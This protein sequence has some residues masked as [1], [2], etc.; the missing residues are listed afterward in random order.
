MTGSAPSIGGP[1]LIFSALRCWRRTALSRCFCWRANSFWRFWYVWFP[2]KV[3]VAHLGQPF[4]S[5]PGLGRG[6]S[7]RIPS[8]GRARGARQIRA[9]KFAKLT[10]RGS[11][12]RWWSIPGTRWAVDSRRSVPDLPPLAGVLGNKTTS[13]CARRHR[14]CGRRRTPTVF[15]GAALH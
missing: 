8:H 12:M 11:A 4:D 7:L 14:R 2:I 5:R 1:P 9:R 10:A 13:D 6:L 15:P 3:T